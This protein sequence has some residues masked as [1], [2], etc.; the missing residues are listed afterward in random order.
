MA[1][2]PKAR[3]PSAVAHTIRFAG[4]ISLD[5]ALA[6]YPKD[7]GSAPSNLV[8][9]EYWGVRFL[10]GDST[11]PTDPTT[12]LPAYVYD[13]S[14]P[15]ALAPHAP[16]QGAVAKMLTATDNI[17]GDLSSPGSS[18]NRTWCNSVEINILQLL[19]GGTATAVV[20][21]PGG[22]YIV[23]DD[24]A[25]SGLG[26]STGLPVL[27]LP[28]AFTFPNGTPSATIVMDITIRHTASR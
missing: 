9:T 10:L 20:A 17:I 13:D 24:S 12:T 27:V 3:I 19:P 15:A 11:D 8:S 18:T 6:A 25:T 4:T 2:Q 5:A 1:I 23:L 22:A 14:Q 28:M 16:T 26:E 7:N 21:N